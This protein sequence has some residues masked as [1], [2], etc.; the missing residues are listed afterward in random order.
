MQ[1]T[2]AEG[3]L[4]PPAPFGCGAGVACSEPEPTFVFIQ[5]A[6]A[7]LSSRNGLNSSRNALFRVGAA[8]PL[9]RKRGAI[10]EVPRAHLAEAAR[11]A[12]RT[13]D[14]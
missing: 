13:V 6:L 1:L 8:R 2:E 5:S 7:K 12:W 9:C 14:G 11:Q 3:R 10:V 4:Q